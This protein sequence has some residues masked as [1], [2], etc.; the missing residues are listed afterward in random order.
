MKVAKTNLCGLWRAEK[1]EVQGV[2]SEPSS[3]PNVLQAGRGSQVPEERLG[4][5]V[6]ICFQ[7]KDALTIYREVISRGVQASKPFV[8][9]GMWVTSMSDPDG[10]RIEFESATGNP[11]DT[12]YDEARYGLAENETQT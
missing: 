12:E 3:E 7:C 9:N 5:G 10:Y 2:N 4:V 8:G 1:R 6:S 11:E